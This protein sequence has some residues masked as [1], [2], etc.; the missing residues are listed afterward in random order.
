MLA[1]GHGAAKR[2]NT[3][4]SFAPLRDVSDSGAIRGA[5]SLGVIARDALVPEMWGGFGAFQSLYYR[6]NQLESQPLN[7]SVRVLPVDDS[8]VISHVSVSRFSSWAR[9][10][11]SG[12]N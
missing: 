4:A 3:F 10:S 2:R 11:G 1:K 8:E 6:C 5:G 9:A 7:L 12:M